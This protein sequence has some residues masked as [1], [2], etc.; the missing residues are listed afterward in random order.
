MLKNLIQTSTTPNESIL[1]KNEMLISQ[2]KMYNEFYEVKKE[3]SF[4]K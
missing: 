1:E 2:C 4:V 3:N